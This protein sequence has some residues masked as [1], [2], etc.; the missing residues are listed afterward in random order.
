MASGAASK[1]AS[2]NRETTKTNATPDISLNDLI[3]DIQKMTFFGDPLSEQN[4]IN[5]GRTLKSKHD[6][7]NILTDQA[8]NGMIRPLIQSFHGLKMENPSRDTFSQSTNPTMSTSDNEGSSTD[9]EFSV[10]DQT[11]VTATS[12]TNRRT[13]PAFLA[14]DSQSS[15]GFGANENYNHEYFQDANGITQNMALLNIQNN[16]STI[17]NITERKTSR[18][19]GNQPDRD[20]NGIASS[21]CTPIRSKR[22]PSKHAQRQS[23][24]PTPQRKKINGSNLVYISQ[25]NTGVESKDQAD[26]QPSQPN[27]FRRFMCTKSQ[28]DL[29]YEA[30]YGMEYLSDA[31]S[32]SKT[33][34]FNPSFPA[35]SPIAVNDPAPSNPGPS[36]TQTAERASAPK[37]VLSP[38]PGLQEKDDISDR[39]NSNNSKVSPR[40]YHQP[41]GDEDGTQQPAMPRSFFTSF[42]QPREAVTPKVQTVNSQMS[43]STAYTVASPAAPSGDSDDDDDDDDDEG[44]FSDPAETP[45]TTAAVAGTAA[46]TP[47]DASP[48]VDFASTTPFPPHTP[49]WDSQTRIKAG[50]TPAVMAAGR[51]PAPTQAATPE[52]PPLTMPALDKLNI[53]TAEEQQAF[54]L[55]ATARTLGR[56]PR[57]QSAKTKIGRARAFMQRNFGTPKAQADEDAVPMET[58]RTPSPTAEQPA[59]M[60]NLGQ[61]KT[62]PQRK[63]QQINP[64]TPNQ[65][66][67]PNNFT[68]PQQQQ[69]PPQQPQ[70]SVVAPTPVPPVVPPPEPDYSGKLELIQ[71]K[72]EEAKH[73]Y[74][75]DHNCK[76]SIHAYTIA[77]QNLD[78]LKGMP[79]FDKNLMMVLLSN[80][81]AVLVTVGA[82]GAAAADCKKAL[83]FASD[84]L[85]NEPQFQRDRGSPLTI[86]VLSRL[87]R[88]LLRQGFEADAKRFFEEAVEKADERISFTKRMHSPADAAHNINLLGSLAAQANEGLSDA[89]KAIEDLERVRTLLRE[90]DGSSGAWSFAEPLSIVNKAI[91]VCDESEDLLLAKIQL[92]MKMKR[93]R[94]IAGLLERRAAL[95]V[96]LDDIFVGDLS[97]LNPYPG[98][99]KA[100][101]L[102]ESYFDGEREES[103]RT[104]DK[105]LNSK[106]ASDAILRMPYKCVR[107][108]LRSLRLQER[109]PAAEA[110]IDAL[111]E[112]LKGQ[113]S[114]DFMWIPDERS[115]LE[116][117]MAS[118]KKGDALYANGNLLAAAKEYGDCLK[119]DGEGLTG[120]VYDGPTAGGRLHA[121]LHCNRAACL[122]ASGKHEEALEDCS[123]ALR[124]HPRYMKAML[125]RARCYSKLVRLQESISE[126]N[127]WLE[128][129]EE[130]KRSNLRPSNPVCVF[131][132]PEVAKDADIDIVRK[133][134]EA[135]YV[136][137]RGVD[138][139]AR[140][141]A[142]KRDQDRRTWNQSFSSSNTAQDRREYWYQQESRRWDSFSRRGPRQDY[143]RSASAGPDTA[144]ARANSTGRSY[145]EER[146]NRHQNS[147]GGLGADNST[148]Y[149]VLRVSMNATEDQIKKAFR[150]L[151]LKYHPDKNKEADATAMFHALTLAHDTLIDP[152]SRARYDAE[153][154]SR[155]R[156][157]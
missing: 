21:S 123:H 9:V 147:T 108:Y 80:R 1:D 46:G 13:F 134:L 148:H 154:R 35:I 81:A 54:T 144:H 4:V 64:K 156:R 72:R 32:L 36:A 68:A 150:K 28:R 106:G 93:W 63:P 91:T 77:I 137:K 157:F 65:F 115:K 153:L 70:P 31:S 145:S 82:V 111:E 22:T 61:K 114:N 75:H 135:V 79:C 6:R 29:E 24:K 105:K 43:S 87:G 85:P 143:R 118:R 98:V 3:S 128:L 62:K 109:Y 39:P 132:G 129:V 97:S 50:K 57:I 18:G 19:R 146:S 56:G 99:P 96:K 88:A 110:A 142:R 104:T 136:L 12:T 48:H 73:Y 122:M 10:K 84:D 83:T 102:T 45:R 44:G 51:T 42:T 119:I 151:A 130:A 140:E 14:S 125:R 25:N 86:K 103:I 74:N 20:S 67:L 101:V 113:P 23:K 116:R 90:K 95:H 155:T 92:L 138:A 126:Y 66:R 60:F 47:M 49:F 34:S 17:K 52:Q 139:A 124:I 2:F 107:I 30:K 7:N 26:T 38:R 149:S 55:G 131:D 133:E 58:E 5:A 127:R 15:Q 121:V 78:S 27:G 71:S 152:Q 89:K 69:P 8:W 33:N 53:N 76:L 41:S 16:G 40:A 117:T 94:E 112:L 11:T 100:A 37:S 141:Q 59:V 120:Q